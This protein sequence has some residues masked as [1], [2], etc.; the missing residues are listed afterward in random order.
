[1]T[2]AIYCEHANEMPAVCPCP[3]DCYCKSHSCSSPTRTAVHPAQRDVI[4]TE[5]RLRQIIREELSRHRAEP[6]PSNAM[7]ELDQLALMSA[8]DASWQAYDRLV[9]IGVAEGLDE[10]VLKTITAAGVVDA[11]RT[12]R[13]E[14]T[15][16]FNKPLG[17]GVA[18]S[19]RMPQ[20]PVY[21]EPTNTGDPELDKQAGIRNFERVFGEGTWNTVGPGS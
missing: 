15:R 17:S 8:N 20:R 4:P 1:M 18:D 3:A 14:R 19:L 6:Q 2:S 21:Q 13:C 9:R 16:R 10:E 12:A 7:D 11:I 5:G